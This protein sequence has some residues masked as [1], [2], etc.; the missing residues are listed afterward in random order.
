[1]TRIA[2]TKEIEISDVLLSAAAD[3][4]ADLLVMRMYGRPRPRELILGGVTHD[5]FRH[6][7]V[8]VVGTEKSIRGVWP[9]CSQIDYLKAPHTYTIT[10]HSLP[11]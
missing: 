2:D 8:P 9:R 10:R 5:I 11:F 7:T 4:S 3:F 1:M 6:V